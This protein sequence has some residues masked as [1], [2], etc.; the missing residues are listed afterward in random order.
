MFT[1]IS[2]LLGFR[3]CYLYYSVPS[4]GAMH[5]R[6]S[7]LPGGAEARYSLLVIYGHLDRAGQLAALGRGCFT[8][9]KNFRHFDAQLSK[10]VRPRTLDQA[11]RSA[12][13]WK[14][15]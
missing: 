9:Y 14:I 8:L 15:R 3:F 11:G 12:V 4:A 2:S 5:V 6:T 7:F 1:I 13:H 10:P